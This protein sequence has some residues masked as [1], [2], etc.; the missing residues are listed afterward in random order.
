MSLLEVFFQVLL[1]TFLCVASFMFGA[2]YG[3]QEAL[4]D[5]EDD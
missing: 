5:S 4:N 3:Y 1:M 2:R